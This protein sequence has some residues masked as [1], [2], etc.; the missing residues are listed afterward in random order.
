MFELPVII[1]R[2]III[3]SENESETTIKDQTHIRKKNMWI[4][5]YSFLHSPK[6]STDKIY[7]PQ[8]LKNSFFS[9]AC[10]Q[11]TAGIFLKRTI[12]SLSATYPKHTFFL[13]QLR[14]ENNNF[15]FSAIGSQLCL[16]IP[17]QYWVHGMNPR[18][19]W[20]LRRFMM[21]HFTPLQLQ[22]LL[23][24]HS[25]HWLNDILTLWANLIFLHTLET[26]PT[27]AT[28]KASRVRY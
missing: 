10:F 6:E 19:C 25:F 16:S 24:K 13:V 28:L 27:I 12:E 14:L 18:A 4:L 22:Q 17:R 3:F 20:H 15:L 11:Y 26:K 8:C 5:N 2:L 23:S 7:V 9:G 21:A 1:F